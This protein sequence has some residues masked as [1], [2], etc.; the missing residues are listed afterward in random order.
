MAGETRAK[1]RDI[2]RAFMSHLEKSSLGTFA[3]GPL[4]DTFRLQPELAACGR[5]TTRPAQRNFIRS[6][7]GGLLFR[8]AAPTFS[9][10]ID[11]STLALSKADGGKGI[12]F[13]WSRL[14]PETRRHL[15]AAVIDLAGHSFWGRKGGSDEPLEALCRM[16]YSLNPRLPLLCQLTN[17]GEGRPW[18]LTS[19]PMVWTKARR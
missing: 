8:D 1:L 11:S 10:W 15:F 3:P 16:M 19:Y 2:V 13:P 7:D 6:E 18:P 4:R 9:E 14:S 12:E 17:V 5:L